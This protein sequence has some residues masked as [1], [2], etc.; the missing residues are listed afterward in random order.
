MSSRNRR[1]TPKQRADAPRI[2][3]ALMEAARMNDAWSMID[4]A[5]RGLADSALA[6]IEYLEL[7][8]AETL[9]PVDSLTR[10]AVLATAVFYGEVRLIDHVRVPAR[11]V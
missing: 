5:R 4:T 11:P 10:D 3:R 2:H 9:Q 7:V 6:A 8:D 1:L